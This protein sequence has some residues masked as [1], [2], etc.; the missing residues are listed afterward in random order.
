MLFH[1][2]THPHAQVGIEGV[3]IQHRWKPYA[4]HLIEDG[5]NSL[6]FYGASNCWARDVVVLGEFSQPLG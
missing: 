2:V 4:G 5:F 1:A 3:T 6:E